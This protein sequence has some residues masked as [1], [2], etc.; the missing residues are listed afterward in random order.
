MEKLFR[1][2]IFCLAQMGLYDAIWPVPLFK[3]INGYQ[4]NRDLINLVLQHSFGGTYS[5]LDKYR[6]DFS[7]W[8]AFTLSLAG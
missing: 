5:E 3:R 6:S 2:S 4:T 7:R 8:Y 1:Y